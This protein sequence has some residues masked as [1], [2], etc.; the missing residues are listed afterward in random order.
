MY[1]E[2]ENKWAKWI[3]PVSP[4]EEY[5]KVLLL[6]LQLFCKLTKNAGL[7]LKKRSLELPTGVWGQ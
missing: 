2:R 1:R 4:D 5:M 3:D 7:R 6:F